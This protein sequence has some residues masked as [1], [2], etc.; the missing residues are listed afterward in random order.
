MVPFSNTQ[1]TERSWFQ[2]HCRVVS[3][4]LARSRLQITPVGLIYI[5]LIL[6]KTKNLLFCTGVQPINNAVIVSDEQQRD[7]IIHMHVSILPQTPLPSRLAYNIEQ[8]SMCYTVGPC[9][10]SLLVKYSSVHTP[11]SVWR[12]ACLWTQCC[13]RTV[14]FCF[15]ASPKLAVLKFFFT[16]PYG[17]RSSG[18]TAVKFLGPNIHSISSLLLELMELYG[19]FSSVLTSRNMTNS[20]QRLCEGESRLNHMLKG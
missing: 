17:F 18:G 12:E 19:G 20:W 1:Y 8:S 6:L 4:L 5:N 15:S 9:W 10:L 7:S 14:Y 16:S 2:M 11:H 13:I 3:F